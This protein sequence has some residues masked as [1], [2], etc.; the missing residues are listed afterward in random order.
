MTSIEVGDNTSSGLKDFGTFDAG[1]FDRDFA[2]GTA[3]MKS[4]ADLIGAIIPV[5]GIFHFVA[6]MIV[7]VV[8]EN[9]WGREVDLVLAKK[10]DNYFLFKTQ[11]VGVIDYL[12]RGGR[13]ITLIA[14]S[15]AVGR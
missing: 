13:E 11:F 5:E 9:V 4:E 14:W 12:P 15:D 1:I 6:I 10:F 2:V 8:G 3:G 7:V